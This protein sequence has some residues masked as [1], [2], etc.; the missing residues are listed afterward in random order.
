MKTTFLT[1]PIGVSGVPLYSSF[2]VTGTDSPVR[3]DSSTARSWLSKR[4]ASAGTRSPGSKKIISPGTKVE[5]STTD[6]CPSRSTLQWGAASLPRAKRD[7]SALYS[8]EKPKTALRKTMAKIAVASR[9]SPR[10]TEMTTVPKR[11]KTIKSWNWR[12]KRSRGETGGFVSKRLGPRRC[13]RSRAALAVNPTC[14]FT[15]KSVR[16]FVIGVR[17]Q[18]FAKGLTSSWNSLRSSASYS[19]ETGSITAERQHGPDREYTYPRM[20]GK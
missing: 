7:C 12:K 1:S 14:G 3:F 11:T 9:Y 19:R 20:R 17:C 2:L 6:L 18:L 13:R 10:N 5:A 8:W 15:S 4:R 16:S